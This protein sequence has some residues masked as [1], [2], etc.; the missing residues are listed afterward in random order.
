MKTFNHYP[1]KITMLIIMTLFTISVSA[2]KETERESEIIYLDSVAVAANQ[3]AFK[4]MVSKIVLNENFKYRK[5]L[6]KSRLSKK[7]YI[8][9][10]T[11]VSETEILKH[12][13]K[14][15]RRSDSVHEFISYFY[16]RNL[17]FLTSLDTDVISSL[18]DVIRKSTLNGY[19]DE[20]EAVVGTNY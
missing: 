14:A 8:Y 3:H 9:S 7:Q 17:P 20:W 19:L 6:K 4:K 18:Y 15:A 10:G 2:Q 11:S 12:F 1:A 5:E 16:D 13:K